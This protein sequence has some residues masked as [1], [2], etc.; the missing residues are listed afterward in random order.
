M[1]TIKE[2]GQCQGDDH[3]P[4]CA[5]CLKKL[6][7]LSNMDDDDEPIIGFIPDSSNKCKNYI[8]LEYYGG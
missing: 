5:T 7:W 4:L 6:L 2:L 1:K 8:Q 3:C